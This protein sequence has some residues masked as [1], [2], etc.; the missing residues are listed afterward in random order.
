MFDQLIVRLNWVRPRGRTA[1]PRCVGGCAVGSLCR[2][3]GDDDMGYVLH[4]LVTGE[5]VSTLT[6]AEALA[7]TANFSDDEDWSLWRV[8][9]DGS[10]DPLMVAVGRGSS[11]T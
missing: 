9:R 5:D 11:R 3:A 6:E 1:V 4:N 10:G 2:V 8:R 7:R